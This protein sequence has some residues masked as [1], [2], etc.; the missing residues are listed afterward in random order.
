MI[1]IVHY[2]GYL[3]EGM[4]RHSGLDVGKVAL[5]V[6]NCMYVYTTSDR[7]VRVEGVFARYGHDV[8]LGAQDG[9]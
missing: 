3:V 6:Q 9:L 5:F 7:L 1:M 4:L 2:A 8:P